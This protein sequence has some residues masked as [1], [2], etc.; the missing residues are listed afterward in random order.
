VEAP[1][2]W[3]ELEVVRAPL[4]SAGPTVDRVGLDRAELPLQDGWIALERDP[5]RLT[6][7]LRDQPPDRDLV[8]PYLAAPAALAARWAGHES[9]HAG[10]IIAGGGA[11]GVLGDKENGK[12]TTLAWLAL[13]G[14]SVLA[15]DVLVVDQMNAFAGPRCLDL[16]EQAAERLG[17]GEALGTVGVRERW[18]LVLQPVPPCVP[19]RGWIILGWGDEVEMEPVRG[20]ERMLALLP[21]RTVRLAPDAPENLIE[22]S[23]LPTWRLRRPRSWDSL[24][25]AVDRLLATIGD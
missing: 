4:D 16:R 20:P 11:W 17:A 12:S 24:A 19:L 14:H 5:G 6:F 2:S 22:L 7:R 3:P 9:F 23:S 15:D 18:R 8:H 10:G 1:A 25:L 13:H 21:H